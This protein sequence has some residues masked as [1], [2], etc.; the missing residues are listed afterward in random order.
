MITEN[1]SQVFEVS[2][3]ELSSWGKRPH[4]HNFFE[5]VFVENGSGFQCINQHESE[6]HVGNIFLLPPLDCHSFRISEPSRFYFIRFTDH[7]FTKDD[8]L[9]QYGDWFDRIAYILANYNKVPGDII[10]SEREREIIINNIKSVYQ[11]YAVGDCYSD[12]IIAGSVATILS[13]L[14]RSIENRYVDQ[15]NEIDNR[16]GEILRYINTNVG[17]NEKLRVDALADRFGISPSYFSEYFKKNA[18]T[19][20]K[21]YVTKSKLRIVETKV[22]HSDLSLKEIAYQLGF[23][24]SSHLARCFKKTYGKTVNQFRET[25]LTC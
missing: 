4:K 10:S 12:S 2:V 15:A 18:D 24:D 3:E 13:I 19:S 23:T 11:E 5:I 6:Y 7:F 20:L 8:G 17:N 25:G 16:F 14:A 22:M 21:D 1:A 9:T